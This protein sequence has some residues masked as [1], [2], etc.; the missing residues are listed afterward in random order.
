MIAEFLLPF[1]IL[2]YDSDAAAVYCDI[3]AQLE[4]TGQTIWSL[5][6][7]TGAHALS[8]NLTIL[9]ITS[10]SLVVLTG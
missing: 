3:R 7:L 4:N 10:A 1:E 2:T 8:Q 5:D 6:L 9:P